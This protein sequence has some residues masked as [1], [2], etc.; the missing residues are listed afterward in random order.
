MAGGGERPEPGEEE[1]E[2]AGLEDPGRGER[3]QSIQE[4]F[5]GEGREEAEGP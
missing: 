3:R 4:V 1:K 2:P 5:E